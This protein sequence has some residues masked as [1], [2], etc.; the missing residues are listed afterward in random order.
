MQI[1][2]HRIQF[3]HAVGDRCAGRKYDAFVAG[4]FIEIFALCRHVLAFLRSG[5]LYPGDIPHFCKQAEVLKFVRFI[6]E[7]P[8]YAKLLKGDSIVLFLRVH[9]LFQT[10]F[11]F[12]FKAFQLL[13]GEIL[14]FGVFCFGQAQ[15]QIIELFFNM[16]AFLFR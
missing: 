1:A 2:H 11:Q 7:N 9:Q 13:N 4:L 5:V 16:G 3:G 8:V 10:G 15:L 14:G 6:Y 12:L